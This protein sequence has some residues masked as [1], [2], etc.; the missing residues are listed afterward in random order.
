MAT[1][2]GR[3]WLT[4]LWP[5][6][7]KGVPFY[8][9]Q[10]KEAG[11]RG[12]VVHEFPNRDDPFVEDLG[13]APRLYSG[14]AYVHGDAADALAAALKTALATRGAG[15][16][17]VPYFGPVMVHCQTFERVTE[18]DR[19]G[20]VA[21]DLKFVR[22]GAGSA[23]V[24]IP[25]LSSIAFQAADN[26][27]AA[28]AQALPAMVSTFGRPASAV[29]AVTD[30]LAQGAA[31]LD[32]IRQTYPVDPAVSADVRDAVAPL[33][34]SFD[35]AIANTAPP[36]APAAAAAAVLVALVR[37]TMDAMPA[38]AAVRASLELAASFAA[39]VEAPSV[40]GQVVPLAGPRYLAPS[41]ALA[42]DNA[43]AAAR[44]VRLAALTAYAEAVLR[45]TFATRP[46]GVTARGELAERFENEFYQTD[47]AENAALFLAIEQLRDAVIAWLTQA[48]ANLA[49]VIAIETN[50]QMPSLVLAWT[51]YADPMRADELAARNAVRDP[52]FM[53]RELTALSR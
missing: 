40:V 17:V 16:L 45:S 42:A 53:P 29:S 5:A 4:T 51:L 20:Y 27:A 52:M 31:A 6:S 33:I 8:F 34:A 39:P 49:P 7:F 3:D 37:Q 23:L 9:E 35:A 1:Q 13:E 12:L 15:I 32:V 24:S 25:L 19:M 26:L 22:K 28:I 30:T 38:A 50:R 11:G 44:V 46:E 48:I 43:A 10:D 18:R 2:P 47:G 21:F 36:A 14:A 41:Q